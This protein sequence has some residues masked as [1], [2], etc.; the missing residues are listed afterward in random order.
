MADL[1]GRNIR[2]YKI[3]SYVG[4]GGHGAVYRAENMST[5]DIVALK[6]LLPEHSKDSELKKRLEQEVEIFKV[7][8]HPHIVRLMDTWTDEL[9]VW[10]LMPWIGGGD[11][12]DRLKQGALKPEELQPILAQICSALDAAH[13]EQIIHRDIKP[14][15]ILLDEAGQAYLSD[16]GIAKRVN[17]SAITMMGIVVGSPNY[18]SPEQIMDGQVSHRSDVFALGITIYEL[19][20]GEHPYQDIVSRLKLMQK[21]VQEDLPPL[22][23]LQI[24]EKHLDGINNL[25]QRC[26]AK[27]P[28]DRY[29][30]ASEVAEE[31]Q[32]ILESN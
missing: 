2:D 30:R 18:L 23:S 10:L 4:K 29:Q 24:Q 31:F 28:D 5:G 13:A 19:L 14:D 16:F 3:T 6:V 26:T 11:L 32:A 22:V 1:I 7:L 9:G 21:L 17:A 25:I 12:R 8:R 27:N 15:N 20:A